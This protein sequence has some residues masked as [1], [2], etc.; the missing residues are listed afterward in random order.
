MIELFG[1]V[2]AMLG[3]TEV[4]YICGTPRVAEEGAYEIGADLV[5]VTSTA[6]VIATIARVALDAGVQYKSEVTARPRAQITKVD[7]INATG[8]NT[9]VDV[10]WPAVLVA[11]ITFSDDTTLTV[12]NS[13]HPKSAAPDKLRELVPTLVGGM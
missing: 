6:V 9:A 2:I 10:P 8:L 1:K 12:P 7:L 13:K 4:L 5:F 3:D 11:R